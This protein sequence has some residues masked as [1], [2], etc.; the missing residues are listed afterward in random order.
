M[1]VGSYDK[2]M[3]RG[4]FEYIISRDDALNVSNRGYDL[5]VN[6]DDALDI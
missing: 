6:R 5:D 1:D 2:L 3:W 4:C